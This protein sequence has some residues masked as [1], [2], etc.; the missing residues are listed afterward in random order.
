MSSAASYM[1]FRRKCSE[2]EWADYQKC[3]G[4]IAQQQFRAQWAEA[5]VKN[6]SATKKNTQQER[7]SQGKRGFYRPRAKILE[8]EGH[9]AEGEVAT[10]N[11]IK[12]ALA[13]GYPFVAYNEDTERLEYLHRQRYL[14][15]GFDRTRSLEIQ[16][17]ADIP[18]EELQSVLMQAQAQGL[19]KPDDG[20]LEAERKKVE[21]RLRGEAASS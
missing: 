4:N 15:E 12:K 14:D 13:K 7:I 6:A 11:I 17:E 20:I 10:D 3:K 18:E 5:R 21:A 16:G 19:S 1:T 8:E 2:Q 9:D